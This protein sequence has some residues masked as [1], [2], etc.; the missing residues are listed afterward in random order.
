MT[1]YSTMTPFG[2]SGPCQA[3]VILSLLFLSFRITFTANRVRQRHNV[4]TYIENGQFY[5]EEFR[6]TSVQL[7]PL[8][9]YGFI[10]VTPLLYS[11]KWSHWE[12]TIPRLTESALHTHTQVKPLSK[13]RQRRATQQQVITLLKHSLTPSL[14]LSSVPSSLSLQHDRHRKRMRRG[15]GDGSRDSRSHIWSDGWR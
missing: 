8:D 15:E 7:E 9:P 5:L 1:S 14:S 4:M 2:L 10:P 6:I 12:L 11:T 3:S 13:E